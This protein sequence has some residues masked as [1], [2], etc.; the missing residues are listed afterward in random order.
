MTSFSLEDAIAASGGN[1]ARMLRNDPAGPYQMPFTE[2]YTNWRD[3][4]SAWATSATLFDQSF[5][6]NDITFSGPDVRR[7]FSESGVNSFAAFG[8]NKAK[9]FVAVSP[10]GDVIGDGICFGF[11]DDRYVLV[12]TPAASDWVTFR[13]LT[14]GYDVEVAADPATP[15]NPNPREKFRFQI[16]GPRSLDIVRSLAGDVVDDIRFFQMGE[17]E[18]AGVP[19]RALNHTMIGVPGQEH[20]GLEMTGPWSEHDRVLEALHGA[21]APF[22]MR[23][24]GSLAYT[25]TAAS[26]GWFATPIPGVYLGDELKAYREWLPG[27]GYEAHCSVG[28]SLESD[29]IRDYYLTPWD[30][31]YGRVV[32]FDH[33]FVGRDALQ[34]R[35]DEPHLVKVFLRW[36][37]DDAAAVMASSTQDY[38]RGAKFMEMPSAHYAT[39]HYD[40][41]LAGASRIGV[42]NWPVYT[43]N[44]GGW[45]QLGLV[46][47]AHAA[48]GT[49]L[50]ILWGNESAIGTKLRVEPHR[51]RTVR[52]TVHTSSPVRVH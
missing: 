26:S 25:T 35:K 36:N 28:G 8:R 34:A 11:D 37:E 33:E 10:D 32:N 7:L 12:G 41:V 38:P 48:D 18:I 6:M 16:Q 52:V 31:G 3:E 51:A 29:D 30:L 19:V 42:A 15:F 46:E 14:G 40:Q 27:Y 17:F 13:A 4:Q 20:T 49:E 24:G 5:H 23:D 45:V 39:A 50:E 2:Q 22:E 9:Q 1:P 47:E 43:V 44:F 21:G